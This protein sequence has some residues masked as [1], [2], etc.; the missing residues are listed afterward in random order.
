VFAAPGI[1]AA[2]PRSPAAELARLDQEQRALQLK[3]ANFAAVKV[4]RKALALQIQLTGPDSIQVERRKQTLSSLLGAIGDTRGQLALD[5]ELLETAERL[6][7]AESREVLNA[8]AL[9]IGPYWAANRYDELE[10]IEQRLL[11]LTEKLDGAHSAAYASQLTA[12]GSLLSARGQLASAEQAYE[13]ALA[14]QEA[15]TTDEQLL[16][17]PIETLA[18]A[19]WQANQ[20][21]RAIALFDRALAI[22]ERPGTPEWTR[23]GT[24]WMLV[25]LYHSGGRDDLAEPLIQRAVDLYDS[26]IAALERDSPDSPQLSATLGQLGYAHR[27]RGDLERAAAA[28]ERAIAIDAKYHR[29]SGWAT[30]LAEVRRLQGRPRDALALLETART[31][32][33]RLAP[34]NTTSFNPVLADVLRELGDY[35]RAERLLADYRASLAKTYGRRHP[36]YGMAELSTAYLDMASGKPAAASSCSPTG[37]TSPSASSSW[38]CAPAPRPITRCTSRATPTSSTRRSTSRSTTR[39]TGRRPRGSG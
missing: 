36:L 19:Y 13:Q 8:L 1:A 17:G 28:F 5:Q 30:T 15:L 2:A 24:L 29:F 38:R 11:A 31:E 33:A 3:Q 22:S 14:I 9:V 34:Q 21:T 20:R 12:Y 10:V 25:T 4:A 35:P 16:L 32:L 6:H 37:S 18:S 7:G 23:S 39:P 27:Q 26:Q